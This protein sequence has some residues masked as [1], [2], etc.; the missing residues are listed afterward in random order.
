MAAGG[1]KINVTEETFQPA[2]RGHF[3]HVHS[4]VSDQVSRDVTMGSFGAA[5]CCPLGVLTRSVPLVLVLQIL[6]NKTKT[7]NFQKIWL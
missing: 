3:G 2:A 6:H 7:G 1:C 5:S 4:H